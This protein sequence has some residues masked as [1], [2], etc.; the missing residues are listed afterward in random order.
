AK[1]DKIEVTLFDERS[2]K[3]TVIGRDPRTDLALIKIDAKGLPFVTFGD[4]AKLEVGDWVMA[5]GNPHGLDHTVTVGI[6]SAKGR[7]IFGGTAYGQFLQTDAAIN[8][9]NSGGP[10]FD[11]KGRV[12]GIN[13]AIVAGG[14]GLGFAVPIN[15]AK[16][17]IQQLRT[18]GRVERGWFGVGIQNVNSALAKS[19]GLPKR[20]RGVL[21]TDVR[22]DGPAFL[23]GLKQGDIV[24]QYNGK[25]LNKTTD[26]QR[27][28][29]ET[30]PGKKIRVKI[31]R[32]KKFLYKTVTVGLAPTRGARGEIR[33]VNRYGFELSAI[34]REVRQKYRIQAKEGLLIVRIKRDKTAW[35]AGLRKG[36]VIIKVNNKK[37]KTTRDFYSI[38]DRFGKDDAV[39]LLVKR[40]GRSLYF[41]LPVKPK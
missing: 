25:K 5:I 30:K 15:I 11:V 21:I 27:A 26:L 16:S 19:F 7:D 12:I 20:M 18:K 33:I 34:T 24:V 13:T 3:A 4:S 8:P 22:R 31:F 28:V 1:A 35:D 36:D 2:F 23:G 41:A 9:G 40:K 29:A 14:Q 39:S 37:V 6:L 17:V 10:L 32:N 38:L